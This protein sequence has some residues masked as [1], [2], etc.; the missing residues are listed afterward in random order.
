[1]ADDFY[2]TQLK[3]LAASKFYSRVWGFFGVDVVF[4]PLVLAMYFL[5]MGRTRVVVL[6][7]LAA[8]VA[9][10]VVSPLIFLLYKKERPYQAL[11]FTLSRTGL[12]SRVVERHNS[13]PS[14]HAVGLMAMSTVTFL[15]FP[16][17]GALL[18]VLTILNGIGRVILG[19]HYPVDVAAGW[20]LG[21][22]FG[23]LTVYFFALPVS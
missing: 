11:K 22:I 20:L 2:S 10:Y 1:M 5:A 18:F 12:F 13:F 8:V 19:Y 17:W 21:I 3:K 7:F 4:L 16:L 6:A 14:D 23:V 15:Y 9:R